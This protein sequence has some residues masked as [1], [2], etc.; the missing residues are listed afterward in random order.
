VAL[1]ERVLG[2]GYELN[3]HLRKECLGST[4]KLARVEGFASCRDKHLDRRGDCPEPV[5]VEGREQGKPR[6][7]ADHAVQNQ[8]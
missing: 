4:C 2:V 1:G 7:M 5:V 8:A 3:G 6:Y